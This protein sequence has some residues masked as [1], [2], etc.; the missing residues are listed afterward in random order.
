ML[1][2]GISVCLLL[3]L[4]MLSVLADPGDTD[5]PFDVG[6]TLTFQATYELEFEGNPNSNEESGT[7]SISSKVIL[8]LGDSRGN[9]MMLGYWKDWSYYLN[10]THLEHSFTDPDDV[11]HITSTTGQLAPNRYFNLNYPCSIYFDEGF[12]FSLI[13]NETLWANF[14]EDVQA[15]VQIFDERHSDLEAATATTTSNSISLTNVHTFRNREGVTANVSIE[16]SEDGICS[17]YMENMSTVILYDTTEYKSEIKFTFSRISPTISGFSLEWFSLLL[18][19][20]ILA[21]ISIFRSRRR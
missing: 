2:F 17:E 1:L 3:E 5:L 6:D 13:M 11:A 18:G 20:S 12:R 8:K 16:Y 9:M 15:F 21:L 19:G 14:T 10:D 4:G 7:L